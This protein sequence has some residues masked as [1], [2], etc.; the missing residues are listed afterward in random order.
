LAQRREW[1]VIASSD[2]LPNRFTMGAADGKFEL[3][4]ARRA[5]ARDDLQAFMAASSS[6][7]LNRG[8]NAASSSLLLDVARAS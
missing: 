8:Q 4:D 3:A 6:D 7:Q 1:W 5:K 2:L